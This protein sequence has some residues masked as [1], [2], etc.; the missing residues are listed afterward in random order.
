ML[1]ITEVNCTFAVKSGGHA[2]FPGASNIQDGMT[3]DMRSINEITISPDRKTRVLGTGNTWYALYK[4]LEVHNLTAVGARAADVG[5]GGQILGA[6]LD[7][8]VNLGRNISKDPSSSNGFTAFTLSHD[9]ERVSVHLENTD[10]IPYPPIFEE[11]KAIPAVIE[12]SKVHYMSEIT[13]TLANRTLVGSRN[14]HWTYTF[15]LDALL[16]GF[17]VD[18]FLAAIQPL[19]EIEGIIADCNFQTITEPMLSHM[20]GNAFGLSGEEGPYTLLLLSA[21]WSNEA[22]DESIYKAFNMMQTIKAKAK[23]SGL[24]VDY[25]FMNYASQFQD[26][27]SSYGAENVRRLRVASYNDDPEQF[28]ERLQPGYFKLNGSAPAELRVDG[29]N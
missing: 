4:A 11:V 1:V 3:F 2:T 9:T 6:V 15:K 29:N 24:H 20:K 28:L 8:Y 5:V 10:G 18:I 7:A 26:V 27:I 16:A 19:R 21:V 14:T 17:V 23:G 22:D 12:A 25:L 13:K